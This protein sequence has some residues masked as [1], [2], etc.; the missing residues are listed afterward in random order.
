MQL[1]WP[2]VCAL[3]VS[4]RFGCQKKLQ[5]VQQAIVDLRRDRAL[6]RSRTE[7]CG[8]TVAASCDPAGASRAETLALATQEASALPSFFA[9]QRLEL[10]T[11]GRE[12]ILDGFRSC[13]W[14]SSLH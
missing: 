1:V 4:I 2:R 12:S 10:G 13:D 9:K 8:E 3:S 5:Q 6:R 7:R 14:L 11:L